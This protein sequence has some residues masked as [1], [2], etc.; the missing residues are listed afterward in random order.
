MLR[1][2]PV[3]FW[4]RDP[5]QRIIMQS[6]ESLRLWGDLSESSLADPGVAPEIREAWRENN[7][8]VYSGETVCS[9]REYS[10]PLSG[11]RIFHEVATPIVDEG[12]MLGIMGLN[13]DV[14]AARQA[15]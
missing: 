13:I 2:L 10:L 6:R 12:R 7:R 15:Q 11:R 4:A 5:E 9:H 8:K 1:N 3:D 14:I